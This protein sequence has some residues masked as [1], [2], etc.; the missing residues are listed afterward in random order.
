GVKGAIGVAED[1]SDVSLY[2]R[3]V[4]PIEI[5][6]RLKNG[7]TVFSERRSLIFKALQVVRYCDVDRN[8]L[9]YLAFSDRVIQ[10]SPKNSVSAGPIIAYPGQDTVPKCAEHLK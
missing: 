9:V 7:E 4:G 3:Q 1:T 6:S 8:T 10:G 2:C 5:K